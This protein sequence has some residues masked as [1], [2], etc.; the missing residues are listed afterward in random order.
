MIV[1]AVDSGEVDRI[2]GRLR[3]LGATPRE[4]VAPGGLGCQSRCLVLADAHGPDVHGH[5][6]SGAAQARIAAVLR[7]EGE[8]AVARPDGGAALRAWQRD[9]APVVFGNRVSVCLAHSEHDRSGL[10]AVVEL[11]TGGFGNGHH[12]STRLAIETLADRLQGGE[13]V[14]DVGCGSGVLGLVALAF[15]AGE[16]VAVDRKPEAVEAA[17]RNA[18]INGWAHRLRTA[19]ELQTVGS[20]FEVVA[21]NIARAGIVE[22]ATELVRCTAAGGSL[23]LSGLSPGQCSQAAGFLSPLTVA[24]SRVAGDWALLVMTRSRG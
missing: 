4:A 1:V 22:L 19:D 15:G 7:D 16:V 11:G 20:G 8:L 3:A 9:T 2:C 10:P 23:I 14:L 24:E 17:R 13:R 12:P 18:A 5:A 21:A 6:D